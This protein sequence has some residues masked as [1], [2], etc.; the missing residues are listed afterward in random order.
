[1]DTRPFSLPCVDLGA[2]TAAGVER[3]LLLGDVTAVEAEAVALAA[4][5]AL[6]LLQQKDD[7]VVNHAEDPLPADPAQRQLLQVEA[8]P[9]LQDAVDHS[10]PRN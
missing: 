7:G 3:Q 9:R 4:G 8:G 1:M 5:G 2:G 10:A 6:Q